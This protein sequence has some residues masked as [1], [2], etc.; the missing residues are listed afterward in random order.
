M[1]SSVVTLAVL[2]LVLC[3]YTHVVDA[4]T[5]CSASANSGP[6][7][8]PG[9]QGP[10]GSQGVAGPTGATGPAVTPTTDTITGVFTPLGA[11]DGTPSGSIDI[12][13]ST[14]GN[15]VWVDV[16]SFTVTTGTSNTAIEFSVGLPTGFE[17]TNPSP[18]IYYQLIPSPLAVTHPLTPFIAD[19]SQKL[20]Y[21]ALV[22][23]P[24]ATPIVF[25][26]HSFYYL[27]V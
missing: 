4:G 2:A 1:S 10:V 20:S 18:N 6:A 24:D 8:P 17:V 3:C 26:R 21:S 25:Q 9:P 23:L 22:N 12:S 11:V 16:P 13:L 15:V 14:Y 19:P 27:I 7:G 5:C